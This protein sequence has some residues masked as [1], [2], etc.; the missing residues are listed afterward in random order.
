MGASAEKVVRQKW[1]LLQATMDER[2]RRLWSG[3]EAGA[4]G[5]GG[6]AAVARTTGM[7]ISTARKGRDEARM[8]AASLTG[9]GVSLLDGLTLAG[10]TAACTIAALF[11]GSA[12]LNQDDVLAD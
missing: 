9:H 10:T 8:I 2:A 6:V 5:W 4:I 3:T 1:W 12:G 7:A 11:A